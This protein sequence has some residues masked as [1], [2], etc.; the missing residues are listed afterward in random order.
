MTLKIPKVSADDN[1]NAIINK[2][3]ED[4][5]L[6]VDTRD[7]KKLRVSYFFKQ[8]TNAPYT[9]AKMRCKKQRGYICQTTSNASERQT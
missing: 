7:K 4:N 6:K 2:K 9:L 8:T 5:S 3:N 1:D